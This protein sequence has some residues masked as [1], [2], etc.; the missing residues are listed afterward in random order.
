ATGYSISQPFDPVNSQF[1]VSD[2]PAAEGAVNQEKRFDV[3][4]DGVQWSIG[5]TIDGRF[6]A[7]VDNDILSNIDT[8]LWNNEKKE[9]AKKA[10]SN[11]LKQFKNGIV[12]DGVTRKVNKVSRNEYTRSQYTQKLYKKT[13]NVF[14]DKM[15]AAEIADDIVIATTNRSRDGALTHPR[16]DNFV[17]FDHGD[18]LIAS[19][20]AKYTAEVVVGITND[21]EAVFYDVVDLT[22]TTFEIKNADSSTA[23]TTQNAIGAIY[24]ES[25]TDSISQPS[26]SVNRQFSVSGDEN[27]KE[28]QLQIIESTNP[29]P[30]T[31]STWIRTAEDIKTLAETLEDSDWVDVDTFNPDLTRDDIL[32]AI[33]SGKIKI[34][35]SYPIE[36]GVFV[37]PSYME[38]ESYSGDGQVYAKN[39]DIRNVA[40]IDPTQG[41]Y[42][43]VFDPNTGESI[44][45]SVEGDEGEYSS[46]NK[47]KSSKGQALNLEYEDSQ[48]P[49]SEM[50]LDS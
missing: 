26:D 19:G 24:E 48:Q 38:A 40:W 25:V 5:E 13:P 17:D 50:L 7:I 20:D 3:G 6:V 28:A 44:Q 23:A 30:N 22:P 12:V 46:T 16:T 10:A 41:Q 45:F 43:E 49:T 34:Y 21:D 47:R 11:A 37:S 32:K 39:A 35:S 33:K 15:R 18:T 2:N 14:A 31:Y 27:Y 42:A 29:A 8:S 1:S 9:A 4:E 36:N